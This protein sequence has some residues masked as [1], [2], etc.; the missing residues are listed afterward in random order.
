M[1]TT[2]GV[3]ALLLLA[4]LTA[5]GADEEPRDDSSA[6]ASSSTASS[7]SGTTSGEPTATASTSSAT[8]DGLTTPGSRLLVGEAATVPLVSPRGGTQVGVAEVVVTGIEPV[9]ADDLAGTEVDEGQAVHVLRATLT[10]VELAPDAGPLQPTVDLNGAVDGGPLGKTS[11]ADAD[12]L[13]CGPLDLDEDTAPGTVLE[14]C[15]TAV[16]DPDAQVDATWAPAGSAYAFRTGA[17]VVWAG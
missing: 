13:G 15:V 7:S 11:S 9:P 2:G 16:S 6:T 10:V 5:C 1:R 14:M 12:A 17:P 8:A 3:A 4:T